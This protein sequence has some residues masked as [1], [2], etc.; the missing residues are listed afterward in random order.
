MHRSGNLS[1]NYVKEKKLAKY[2]QIFD[3][4]LLKIS[5]PLG[6]FDRMPVN[7]SEFMVYRFSVNF[8]M[9]FL[10]SIPFCALNDRAWQNDQSETLI[11]F[12]PIRADCTT[13]PTRLH[14]FPRRECPGHEIYSFLTQESTVWKNTYL[15]RYCTPLSSNKSVWF[16]STTRGGTCTYKPLYIYPFISS[17]VKH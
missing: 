16:M 13:E 2:P 8:P 15:R 3:I 9:K 5:V 12:R 7:M 6:I 17:K 14:L 11:L 10:S 1:K 4:F